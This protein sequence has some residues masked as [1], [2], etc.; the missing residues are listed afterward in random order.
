L[1]EVFSIAF[2][3]LSIHWFTTTGRRAVT[4]RVCCFKDEAKESSPNNERQD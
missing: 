1:R 3:F 4:S 2:F